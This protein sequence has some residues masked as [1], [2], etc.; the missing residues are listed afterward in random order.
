VF[1]LTLTAEHAHQ[2]DEIDSERSDLE[3]F[4]SGEIDAAS[5]N[6]DLFAPDVSSRRYSAGR[7]E[8]PL[9]RSTFLLPDSERQQEG[10]SLRSKRP[11]D[12]SGVP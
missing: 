2:I 4:R 1:G 10:A 3:R 12:V 6:P 11:R 9:A 5:F 7:L 8:S